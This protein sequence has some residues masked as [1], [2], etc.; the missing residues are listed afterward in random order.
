MNDTGIFSNQ[1]SMDAIE[2]NSEGGVDYNIQNSHSVIY[3]VKNVLQESMDQKQK[4]EGSQL[5]IMS[6]PE[7]LDVI[8]Y[9]VKEELITQNCHSVFFGK[10]SSP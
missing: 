8:E 7:S 10:K 6:K 9:M 2:K 1:E 5:S 4:K 3:E